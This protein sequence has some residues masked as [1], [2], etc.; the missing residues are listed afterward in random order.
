M[1]GGGRPV[2]ELTGV[3]RTYDDGVPVHALRP[4]DLLVGTGDYLTVTGPSGA[5]KSTLLNVLGLLDRPTAGSYRVAGDETSKA[6]ERRRVTL[7]GQLFGFVFQA[8]HLLPGRS[9]LENVELGMVYGPRPVRER[10]R[11]AAEALDRVGMSAR[12]GADPRTLSGGE[13]Q[14]VAIARAVA[15]RPRVLFCDEPTGNL[16]TENSVRVLELIGELHRE[17][18]T[19]VVVTHD[20]EVAAR[21]DRRIEVRDGTVTE[22]PAR[23][24]GPVPA[25]EATWGS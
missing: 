23:A 20:A 14:R 24:A 25:K 22:R 6:D 18:I 17:G 13:R 5:G 11:L 7:R 3:A 15:G 12:S 4:V 21:G 9:A 8:F 16:D 19:L 10:R 2:L 1:T